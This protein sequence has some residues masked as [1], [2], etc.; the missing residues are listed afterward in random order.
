MAHL[1]PAVKNMT[2]LLPSLTLSSGFLS[3]SAL[4]TRSL[5]WPSRP[6]MIC[7]SPCQYLKSLTVSYPPKHNIHLSYMQTLSE[8]K[9]WTK[10]YR[11]RVFANF[12]PH[13]YIGLPLDLWHAKSL[14]VF[15]TKLKTYLFKQAFYGITLLMFVIDVFYVL[16]RLQ[17]L[18]SSFIPASV[19]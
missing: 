6:S 19:L 8:P 12:E 4:P 15:K 18:C 13:V 3:D 7:P 9:F 1:T 5:F 17:L 2:T 16:L 14:D 11:A 10:W